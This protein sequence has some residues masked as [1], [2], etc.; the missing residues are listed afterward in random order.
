MAFHKTARKQYTCGDCKHFDKGEEKCTHKDMNGKAVSATDVIPC[1]I[2]Y[3]Q[4]LDD[5]ENN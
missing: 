2:G 3:F 4:A 1:G 5:Y